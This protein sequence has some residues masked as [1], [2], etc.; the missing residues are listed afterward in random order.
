MEGKRFVLTLSA[1]FLFLG[2]WAT[3]GRDTGSGPHRKRRHRRHRAVRRGRAVARP[4][5]RVVVRPGEWA[6][7]VFVIDG[8]T[9]Y[10][11]LRDRKAPLFKARLAGI[12]APECRKRRARLPTGHWAGRCVAD[13]EYFGLAAYELL[14]NKVEGKFVRIDCPTDRTGDCRH[15]SYGRPLVFLE[16]PEGRGFVDVGEWLVERGA[17][18]PFTKYSSPRLARYC[19][20]E[21][22]AWKT[23]AGMWRAGDRWSVLARMSKKTQRWYARRDA[24]CRKLVRKVRHARR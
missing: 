20:A 14:K 13:E 8:D 4:R 5:R 16:L 6:K 19:L 2:I 1:V 11:S 17:A 18:W 15:G 24:V 3:C 22:R 23:R 7:V 10:L 9:V 12:N 21:E